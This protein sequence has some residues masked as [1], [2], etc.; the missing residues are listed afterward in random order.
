[1]IEVTRE[2]VYNTKVSSIV[3]QNDDQIK[4]KQNVLGYL[5]V[6]L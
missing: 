2:A 4:Y 1:M 5:T 6:L 3:F